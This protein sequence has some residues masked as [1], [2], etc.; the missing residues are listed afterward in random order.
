MIHK[1]E[2]TIGG[3]VMSIE[4]GRVAEQAGGAVLVRYGDTVVLGTA[5]ASEG[6]RE[7]IDFF[8]LTVDV[9]ER[10]YAAGKI[11]GG[12]IKREG[13]PTEHSILAARLTDRP[14]RPLFPKGYRN[15]VQVVI[16]VLSADMENDSDV[17]G[18]VAASAALTI[19]PIPFAGPVG[20][21]RV[22]YID[23]RIV[24]NPIESDLT[25]S[26]LD[27]VVAGT[28]DAVVMVE[29][30]AKELP[31]ET[32]V[33]AIEAGHQAIQ[34]LIQLQNQ[35][36]KMAGKPKQ[37]FKALE[38][39][40]ALGKAVADFVQ[41][42]FAKAVNAPTKQARDDGINAV[43]SQLLAE[44]GPRHPDRNKE[45]VGFFDKELKAFVRS[46]ILDKGIRPDGRGL[47]DIRPIWCEAGLLPRTHGSAIFTR[48]QTQVL[49]VVTLGTPGEEQVV[50]GVGPEESK[51]YIHHYNF[52]S[53]STG[54]TRP[55]RGP[56]RREIGHGALAERALLPVIPDQREFPYTIRI[57]SEVL[58][59][60]GSTSMGSTCGSTLSLMDAGVPI[61]APVSGVAMGLITASGET[62]D[63]YA[64]LTDIQGIEDAMGDMDFKVAGTADGVTALQMDI[65]IKGLTTE[66]LA[67]GDGA[68]QRGP[69]V[70]H[71]Q[72][73]RNA[74]RAQAQPLAVRAAHSVGQGQPGQDRRHHRPRR[75]DDSPHPGRGGREDR[76]RR[77]R[78]RA[79]FVGDR[80]G[81]EPRTQRRACADRG[82]RG[83]QDL[84]R[85]GAPPGGFRRLCRDS[86]RQG[87]AGPHLAAC[88]LP[89][90]S[91]GGCGRGWRRGHGDGDRDGPA[92]PHQ[93]FA[94]RGAAG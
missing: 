94:P 29:A 71:G 9:E 78:H 76:H 93:S 3:R 42:R 1:L 88:R 85:H 50:D 52:P 92:G 12:F 17:L 6:P 87:G 89:C 37:Q 67:Q 83:R 90:E 62:A 44:L 53:F 63:R 75:Q 80:G 22:G 7:G 16:T 30:G 68:G 64:I 14:I 25:R 24:I 8:P 59:S 32:I 18:I 73:A 79:Y 57:V 19:S 60:N 28:A 38:P 31:E 46:E 13:R 11:P 2:T 86:A 56:G 91:A 82:G 47:K 69:H 5:T 55:S 21:V 43:R 72:D 34:A 51:R 58:S 45:I 77:R 74:A 81:H 27:L 65:K 33:A 40:A 39:D 48:G 23:G 26:Q 20:A 4:T 49:S 10:M 36:Q 70:H 41:P 15:D 35:L 54:E 61:K 84:H 66:L